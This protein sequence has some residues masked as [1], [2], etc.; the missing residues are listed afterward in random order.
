MVVVVT[1]VVSPIPAAELGCMSTRVA[2]P[3]RGTFHEGSGCIRRI[4]RLDTAAP[5][6]LNGAV[7]T[8]VWGPQYLVQTSRDKVGKIEVTHATWANFTLF[9]LPCCFYRTRADQSHT[10]IAP[11]EVSEHCAQKTTGPIPIPELCLGA[12]SI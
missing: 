5:D 6:R 1:A 4:L 2:V 7:K 8:E 3:R 9:P 11:S 12:L 10:A